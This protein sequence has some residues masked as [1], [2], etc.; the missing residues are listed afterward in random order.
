MADIDKTITTLQ[1]MI[2]NARNNHLKT[3]TIFISTL[4][5]CMMYLKKLKRIEQPGVLLFDDPGPII[6]RC[7]DC[8]WAEVSDNEHTWCDHVDHEFCHKNDWFCA[9]GERKVG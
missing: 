5:D 6:V 1:Y 8:R 2:N 7:K 3:T 9:D 4:S